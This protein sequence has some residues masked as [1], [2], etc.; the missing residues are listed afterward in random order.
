MTARLEVADQRLVIVSLVERL[1]RTVFY[2]NLPCRYLRPRLRLGQ[3]R[4]LEMTKRRPPIQFLFRRIPRV[5]SDRRRLFHRQFAVTDF[6][7]GLGPQAVA[8][9][10]LVAQLLAERHR[11][12]P[13]DL[14]HRQVVALAT[15]GP[16]RVGLVALLGNSKGVR[17]FKGGQESFFFAEIRICL[18]PFEFARR[19]SA[20]GRGR[21]DCW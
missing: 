17:K 10:L 5:K 12:L 7:L 21:R 1:Q 11:F 8:F 19:G 3:L 4:N 6:P 9:A 16:L 20:R 15:D 18:T 2:G 14:I 13:G